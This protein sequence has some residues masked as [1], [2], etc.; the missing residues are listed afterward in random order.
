MY[1]SWISL[2]KC[3]SSRAIYLYFIINSS[4]PV[5]INILNR[6]FNAFGATKQFISDNGGAF[7]GFV[8]DETQ[9]FIRNR[10]IKC[11][12]NY[13][14]TLW[15]SGFFGRLAK[16][17]NRCL[18]KILGKARINFDEMNPILIK[19]QNVLNNRP[20]TFCYDDFTTP[21]VPNHLIYGRKINNINIDDDS[22]IYDEGV[23]TLDT[24]WKQWQAEYL[25]ELHEKQ[26]KHSRSNSKYEIST[27]DIVLIQQ[28]KCRRNNWKMGRVTKIIKERDNFVRAANV[29]YVKNNKKLIITRPVNKLYPVTY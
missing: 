24:F 13:E 12:F 27:D 2:I 18:R 4:G 22:T 1:K 15:T 9:L 8:S 28:D 5:C 26:Q 29:E 20:L 21:L 16:S 19:I 6:F 14:A 17:V 11:I 10:N 25:Q 3:S 7:V 23:N